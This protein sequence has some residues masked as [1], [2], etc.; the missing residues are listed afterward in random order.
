[1]SFVWRVA[2]ALTI[3][4]SLLTHAEALQPAE[5]LDRYLA[6]RRNVQPACSDSLFAVRIDASV[7]SLKKQGSMTGFKRIVRPGEVVYR[8]LRFT[9]DKFVKTQVIARFLARDTDSRAETEE[10]GVTPANYVFIYGGKSAY[11]GREAYVF[12]LNPRR[13]RPSLFRG[14]LWLDA[15]T[16]A[17]VRLWGDLV[18]SPSFF[19]RSFRFVQ[20]YR[21]TDGCAKPLRLL[22]TA[23]TRIVGTVEMT[24][25][26]H[27]ASEETESAD[28]MNAFSDFQHGGQSAQ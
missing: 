2:T 27:P 12:V 17:A 28:G 4:N 8:G 26:L 20:D 18:K 1:M 13:K 24:V 5:A 15:D 9:G 11:N 21:I 6:A 22:L 19:V 25:W 10:I 7:P 23:R 14:E 16:G 3:M